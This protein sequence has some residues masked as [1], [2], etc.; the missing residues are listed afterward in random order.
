MTEHQKAF[1]SELAS[2][3][4]WH[5]ENNDL[6]IVEIVG[7]MDMLKGE[8]LDTAF[9][10]YFEVEGQDDGEDGYPGL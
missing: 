4:R 10:E 2:R 1:Y 7:V 6:T 9:M 3:I 8:C 5:F